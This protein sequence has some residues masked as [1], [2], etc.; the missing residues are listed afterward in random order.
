VKCVVCAVWLHGL[1]GP[2]KPCC[3]RTCLLLL[4]SLLSMEI[5][6]LSHV[7]PTMF[8]HVKAR[9]VTHS[10]LRKGAVKNG[11]AAR[12]SSHRTIF[13]VPVGTR[14]IRWIIRASFLFFLCP[15]PYSQPSCGCAFLCRVQYLTLSLLYHATLITFGSHSNPVRQKKT[16]L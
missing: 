3:R 7:I 11:T 14:E 12:R 4:V 2:L 15:Q 13:R 1:V 16:T 10:S 9:L 8:L 5:E 6:V